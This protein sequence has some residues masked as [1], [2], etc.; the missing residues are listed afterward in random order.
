MKAQG[1]S[2]PQNDHRYS[3]SPCKV[4]WKIQGPSKKQCDI[5]SLLLLLLLLS[6]KA[7]G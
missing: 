7:M 6:V 4:H 3:C 1:R 5:L 2:W